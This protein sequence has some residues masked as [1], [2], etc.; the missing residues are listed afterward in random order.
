MACLTPD[1]RH[2]FD[3]SVLCWNF[4]VMEF[5][6]KFTC[7]KEQ[8]PNFTWF[9]AVFSD[10]LLL[11]FSL[12][13]T[14]LCLGDTQLCSC[15]LGFEN[16]NRMMWS[17]WFIQ[18]SGRHYVSCFRS[19]DLPRTGKCEPKGIFSSSEVIVGLCGPMYGSNNRD[20]TWSLPLR[21]WGMSWSLW[22]QCII[23]QLGHVWNES[24][25]IHTLFAWRFESFVASWKTDRWSNVSSEPVALLCH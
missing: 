9:A 15:S 1:E 19:R 12:S 2:A 24:V 16:G 17:I 22:S 13:P 18:A 8:N 21:E 7:S 6:W 20:V 4:L 3:Y 23:S 14:F 25:F 11:G 5:T 10:W